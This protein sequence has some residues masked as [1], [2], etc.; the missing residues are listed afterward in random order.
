MKKKPKKRI[1][2]ENV[3]YKISIG[4]TINAETLDDAIDIIKLTL[5][6]INI[7]I[8]NLTIYGYGEL[9]REHTD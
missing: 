9:A 2:G 5:D 3:K 7:E 1:N 4:G 8:D 6:E